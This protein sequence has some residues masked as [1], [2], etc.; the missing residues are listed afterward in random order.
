LTYSCQLNCDV[1]VWQGKI[2]D[3][4][5]DWTMYWVQLFKVSVFERIFF[6]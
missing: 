3:F 2:G 6:L 1:P 5:I 4:I